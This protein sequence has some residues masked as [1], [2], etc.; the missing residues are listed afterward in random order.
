MEGKQFVHYFFAI[1][2]HVNMLPRNIRIFFVVAVSLAMLVIFI[3]ELFP[4]HD[5]LRNKQAEIIRAY[6]PFGTLVA[7]GTSITV[8]LARTVAERAHGLSGRTSLDHSQGMLFFFD[9][10]DKYALWM[11]DMHFS[12]DIVWIDA[13][14]QIVDIARGVSPDS[15][16]KSFTPEEPALYV[17]EVVAGK[18]DEWGWRVGTAVKFS[19]H[20]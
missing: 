18:V 20:L 16:P 1:L 3:V 19:P 4:A 17:L 2:T 6:P 10:P 15:Y 14:W 11:P 12:I 7:S 13:N 8:L 5:E 9:T